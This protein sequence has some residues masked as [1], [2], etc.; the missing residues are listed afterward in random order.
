MK[1]SESITVLKLKIPGE[2]MRQKLRLLME[3]AVGVKYGL[4]EHLDICT[5]QHYIHYLKI[6][7]PSW[8]YEID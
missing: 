6:F 8:R 3:Q 1:R 5:M 4:M 2:E 7:R